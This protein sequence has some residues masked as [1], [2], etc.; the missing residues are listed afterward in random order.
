MN[1][2]ETAYQINDGPSMV[3]YPRASAYGAEVL[4]DLFG[5]ELPNGELPSR[6][7]AL[8]IGKG[9]VIKTARQQSPLRACIFS[10]GTRLHDSVLAARTLEAKYPDLGVTVADARSRL[11]ISAHFRLMSVQVHEASRH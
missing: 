3:R 5:T 11:S 10:I 1:M 4:K 7:T 2:V 6:G 8:P 9:R